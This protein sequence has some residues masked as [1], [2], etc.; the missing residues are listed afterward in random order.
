MADTARGRVV[1]SLSAEGVRALRGDRTCDKRERERGAQREAAAVQYIC[2]HG[3]C[4][5]PRRLLTRRI[6]DSV[7]RRRESPGA[8]LSG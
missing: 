3:V 6:A 2:A 1:G 4:C 7:A 5:R 8:R